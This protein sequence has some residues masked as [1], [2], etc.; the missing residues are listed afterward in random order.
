M[1]NLELMLEIHI[2]RTL[3][4]ADDITFVVQCATDATECLTMNSQ[5]RIRTRYVRL[6]TG[7][8]SVQAL[9]SS[10]DGRPF[11]HNRHGP[12]I[13]GAFPLLG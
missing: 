7:N 5:F 6:L 9:S 12:K 11:G 4:D 8:E 13:G 3:T 10:C 1:Q 2:S